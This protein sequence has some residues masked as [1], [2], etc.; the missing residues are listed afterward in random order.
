M[1]IPILKLVAKAHTDLVVARYR[2]RQIAD[3][4]CMKTLDKTKL[5]TAVSELL[6]N[7]IT[8]AGEGR[9]EFS[10]NQEGQHQSIEVVITDYG[11]GFSPAA[12]EGDN[13]KRGL[14]VSR[15]LVDE[16]HIKSESGVG[17]T[18]K[19]TKAVGNNSKRL[20][21]AH[22][23]D[24]IATL[25]K[26]SPFT[27]VEDLEQQNK[28][29]LDTLSELEKT[30][31]KLE[32][33]S[34]QLNQANKYKG[35][36]LAN[37]SHEIRTPMNAVIGMSNILERTDL[38]DEQRKFLR[39]IKDSGGALL[40][41]INDILDFSKIEAGKLT[42]ENL[43][44]DLFDVVE[45]CAEILSTNAQT[46]GLDLIA[47][48]DSDVPK[49]V[50]G[51][52]VRLRQ[53]LVNLINN[54]IKFTETGEVIVRVRQ[55][56]SDAAEVVLRF[57]VIDSGIGLSPDKQQKL[58]K[59]FVQADGSTTRKYGGTGLGLSICKHLVDLMGGNIG[60][61][62]VEGTGSTFWFELPF[63]LDSTS[64]EAKQKLPK[65][66]NAL[67]VDDHLP[68]R[69]MAKFLLDSWNIDAQT[70]G[71]AREALNLIKDTDFDLCILDFK[72][73]EM[74]GIELTQEL[75]K[76]PRLK[77]TQIVLLT[78][79]HEEGL[80]EKAIAAGCN[81]FLNKPLR[82]GQLL[83]CL[84]SLKDT[85]TYQAVPRPSTQSRPSRSPDSTPNVTSGESHVK[86]I[87]GSGVN[88]QSDALAGGLRQVLV[89]E[90][91][92]TNQIVAGI[93]LGN[94]GLEATMANNG[95][96]ALK[97]IEKREFEIV[98]MDCQMPVMDGYETT[99]QLRKDEM[100]TGK[101]LP[102]IAMTANAMEGDRQKCLA[103]G[104]DDY[105]TKP[106]H[107]D[108][109]KAMVAKWLKPLTS[110]NQ[111]DLPAPLEVPPSVA[112]DT[113]D[114]SQMSIDYNQLTSR[115]TKAQANQLLTA[116]LN[117]TE[118]K[119]PGLD[120]MVETNDFDAIA[121]LGHNIHGAAAMIF[122]EPLAVAARELEVAAKAQETSNLPTLKQRL[123]T[124]LEN[125]KVS[126]AKV[127][128][129]ESVT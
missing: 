36:F 56:R 42:I 16:F 110:T 94:L 44:F 61:D 87:I 3:L 129:E 88:A 77:S 79:L 38:S 127:L 102:V 113:S 71:S 76:I 53:I 84:V 14:A 9:I 118:K 1:A 37:M 58:F 12:V 34:E 10:L 120:T 50:L 126:C 18:V 39:L 62:S 59:P 75:R 86:A 64:P 80:G 7:A 85:G 31:N 128:L 109:L 97:L 89:A 121:K 57:E 93:E 60:V 5:V 90:D 33:K 46:K 4:A 99:R 49:N 107:P 41:I 17:T 74:N 40:D 65:F 32:E 104:M 112:P 101:H 105:I 98:F 111:S 15:K 82:Q 54:A 23:E 66:K 125:L 106:F 45:T 69:E 78:A 103:A 92:M 35:E 108:E 72:M 68:M 73:P 63:G 28:Q 100:K 70:A 6:R 11:P 95:E 22:V 48:I 30:K 52:Y 114:N 122:A 19:I 26:N 124:Q 96:E 81:A 83:D 29:L 67:V 27:V 115:F 51:D 20:T 55:V 21:E 91:N 2:A 47:W 8:Y 123:I 117:D 119:L 25:K 116:F 43:S 13:K 24:W